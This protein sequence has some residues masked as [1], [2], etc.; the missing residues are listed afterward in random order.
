MTDTIQKT[1]S[2][3]LRGAREVAQRKISSISGVSI[4]PANVT[5]KARQG[6]Q[7][8]ITVTVGVAGATP[9]GKSKSTIQKK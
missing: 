2:V 8:I 4:G 6:K 1:D 3:G 5:G 7:Y 9:N